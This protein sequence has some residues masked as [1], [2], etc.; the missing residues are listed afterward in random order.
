M[1][2]LSVGGYGRQD[3]M[4]GIYLIVDLQKLWWGSIIKTEW[5]NHKVFIVKGKKY[6]FSV[7]NCAII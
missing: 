4:H 7:L 6:W 2:Y 3:Q 1:Y 5:I